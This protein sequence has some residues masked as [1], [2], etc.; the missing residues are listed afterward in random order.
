MTQ[1]TSSRAISNMPPPPPP[2]PRRRQSQQS[3]Q[4]EYQYS[5]KPLGPPP[6]SPSTRL[7]PAATAASS[8][9]TRQSHTPSQKYTPPHHTR[10]RHPTSTLSQPRPHSRPT[11]DPPE[12]PRQKKLKVLEIECHYITLALGRLREHSEEWHFLHSKLVKAETELYLLEAELKREGLNVRKV[13]IPGA[14]SI[15]PFRSSVNSHRSHASEV[16]RGS[17]DGTSAMFSPRA[18]QGHDGR[19]AVSNSVKIGETYEIRYNDEHSVS[20]CSS[21]AA[22]RSLTIENLLQRSEESN[23]VYTDHD[24]DGSCSS[25]SSSSSRS[26]SRSSHDT[27]SNSSSSSNSCSSSG[28]STNSGN[29]FFSTSFIDPGDLEDV[30]IGE[31]SKNTAIADAKRSPNTT[32][33]NSDNS[34]ESMPDFDVNGVD[35]T[36][37]RAF[38]TSPSFIALLEENDILQH[39][40]EVSLQEILNAS[41]N[42]LMKD[43]QQHDFF[44]RALGLPDS[45]D[46]KK[47]VRLDSMPNYKPIPKQ[48]SKS[49]IFPSSSSTAIVVANATAN[50]ASDV[51]KALTK[52]IA[53]PTKWFSFYET[54]RS[55]SSTHR[56]SDPSLVDN[57]SNN[58]NN[59]HNENEEFYE[60][61]VEAYLSDLQAQKVRRMRNRILLSVFAV[62][63]AGAVVSLTYGFTK[64]SGGND[65]TNDS[66]NG[67]GFYGNPM[68]PNRPPQGPSYQTTAS[69]P[70]DFNST[71]PS[72]VASRNSVDPNSNS[73]AD[74][75]VQLI[76][77]QFGNETR[78]ELWHIINQDG[79]D[80]D[81]EAAAM[82]N[83][84]IRRLLRHD[85]SHLV[86]RNNMNDTISSTTIKSSLFLRRT[87]EAPTS[88]PSSFSASETIV[89]SGGPYTFREM[90]DR[91]ATS[92]Q[93]QMIQAD[94]CLEM[95]DYKFV[96]YDAV[97]DGICCYYGHGKYALHFSNGREI[98]PLSSGSFLG[99]RQET[100]FQ[101]TSDDLDAVVSERTRPQDAATGIA[102]GDESEAPQENESTISLSSF[103]TASGADLTLGLNKAYGI[104]FNLKLNPDV[105]SLSIAGMDLY[106]DTTSD[107]HYEVWVK[108]GLWQTVDD[109]ANPNYMKGFYPVSHG[110][111]QGKGLCTPT[112]T[113]TCDFTTIPIR[114]FQTVVMLAANIKRLAVYVTLESD[115]LIVKDYHGDGSEE[116]D[117]FDDGEDEAMDHSL[118]LASNPAFRVFYGASVLTY[119]LQGADP[120][121]DIRYNKGFLGRIWYRDIANV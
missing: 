71:S 119:P 95:G 93:Y 105:S 85:D 36:T 32:S 113:T 62:L 3:Q 91:G 80:N 7:A 30:P 18:N 16:S 117:L 94:T 89:L 31:I 4:K 14:S 23:F 120:E 75:S 81:N 98:R 51:S 55:T 101:V 96:I 112:S 66:D 87:A 17:V 52:T 57:K 99:Q 116:E 86:G 82:A 76:L 74:F 47:H 65:S 13:H 121:T 58:N 79:N 61:D 92:D 69:S 10:H 38:T 9:Q 97:G 22:D 59:D 15:S 60:T 72:S 73:C 102:E 100:L 77:D 118:V 46:K 20:C 37:D 39:P 25:D 67:N 64:T 45:F 8:S 21:S 27:S 70:P 104:L 88:T 41:A 48:K 29:S 63:M 111:I 2:P 35:D 33:P 110:T 34:N 53:S 26:R 40:D 50:D 106:L 5:Q 78:W 12:N 83:Q 56:P 84:Q 54:K 1:T 108:P 49:K 109:E 114:D 103:A 115:D 42:S 19:G 43:N 28:S 11:S 24:D 90:S 68:T 6:R 107:V 44:V